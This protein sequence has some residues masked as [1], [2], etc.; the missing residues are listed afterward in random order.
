MRRSV[1]R[2][3][4]LFLLAIMMVSAVGCSSG[5]PASSASSASAG[6]TAGT[7][8]GASAPTS[9]V[10]PVDWP[11]LIDPGVGSKGSDSTAI[12]NLYDSLTFPNSDSSISPLVA[13][14]W[15]VSEDGTVYTFHLRDDVVFHSGNKLTASDVKFSM[16]RMLTLGEGYGYLF[17][18][19][20]TATE[21]VDDYTIKF[22]LANP[23]GLFPNMLIR[24][25][26][27]DEKLVMENINPTGS[28]G[29]YGDYG[30][31]WLLTNDAGSGP[32]KVQE[33]RTEEYLIIEKYADY[34]QGWDGKE[35]APD[36]VKLMGGIDTTNMRT[37][38]SR[39][40]IDFSDDAQTMEMYETLEAM[41][42]ID[43]VRA[44]MGV[45]FN[46]CL[47]T[48]LAPTDDIHVRKAMA[49]ATDYDTI[50]NDI[51]AGSIKATGPIP[52]GMAGS[53]TQAESPYTF[54]LEK[55]KAELAQSP[56]YNQ[57]ISGEMHISLTYCSEGGAQQENLAL[58]FQ[59]KMAEIGVTVDIT[60][61]PFAT[62][63]T[64]ATT[65]ETTPNASFVAFAPS[66]LDGSGYLRNRYS[67][68]TCGTWE[69]MEWLQDEEIDQMIQQALTEP[70][71]A[72][73]EALYKEIST[74]LVEMCPT[75]WMADLATTIAVRS[76]HVMTPM[77]EMYQAGES[78]V[79]S[80]GY[81]GYYR[82]FKIVG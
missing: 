49:Y 20:V 3:L 36:T 63:M 76:S 28:Y 6:D 56:Y 73:R 44:P 5:T 8:S 69:Q 77:L 55:A 31:E 59:A 30:K 25:Y 14:D 79:Y 64:D 9:I 74:K 21:V 26:I 52:V 39:G 58:L 82:D 65:V 54:D 4:A 72:A 40:D 17:V 35:A 24:L 51:Y 80:V 68:E 47:N 57:L 2:V 34:W 38:L 42:G 15:D 43:L 23:S 67:S 37:L 81:G 22:T 1:K 10:A 33:M 45:N 66:Y 71:Q 27:L 48:K 70:D 61:K 29:E 13:T 60:S 32:Y 50:I 46:A 78:F 19:T 16:D 62:M 53:L 7:S 11:T 75:I 12:A 18:G 41:D